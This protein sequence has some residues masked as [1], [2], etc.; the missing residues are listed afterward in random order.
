MA[1]DDPWGSPWA[2]EIQ[3]PHPI[4]LKEDDFAVKPTT[5]VKAASLAL[6]QKT[7]SPWDDADD[8]GFGDWNTGS[9]EEERGLGRDGAN[10]GWESNT[11]DGLG[12][13]LMGEGSHALSVSW[14]NGAITPGDGTPKLG[15]SLF[16][17]H[18]DILRQPSPD[19]WAVDADREH[20]RAVADPVAA[21]QPH[22]RSVDGEPMSDPSVEKEIATDVAPAVVTDR[23]LP[24]TIETGNGSPTEREAHAIVD[25]SSKSNVEGVETLKPVEIADQNG[26]IPETEHVSSRPSSSPSEHS[27]PEE[28]TQDSPRTSLDEE[29]KRPQVAR[30]V[31]TKVQELVEHFDGLAKQEEVVAPIVAR[32]GSPARK[33]EDVGEVEEGE[34]QDEMDD[35]G[36]FEDVQS[37]AE[38]PMDEGKAD[39]STKSPIAEDSIDNTHEPVATHEEPQARVV[40]K[41]LGP[42]QFTIDTTALDRLHPSTESE[43]PSEKLFIPDVIPH[44]SFSSTQERKTWYRISRYGPMRKYNTGDDENYVRV[45]WTQSQFRAETL[46]IV[47]RWI[48][49]D[50]ISGRVVLGG[51]S[52]GS[53]IFGWNDSKAAPIPLAAAFAVKNGKQKA[54]PAATEPAVDIPREWPKGLVRTRSTSNTPPQSKSRRKSSTKPVSSEDNIPG[55]QL[56]VA[57]FGWNATPQGVQ[58]SKPQSP[59]HG[60]KLSG[61]S[62]STPPPA[63]KIDPTSQPTSM[64]IS[65]PLAGPTKRTIPKNGIAPRPHSI[66][67]TAI[68]IPPSLS[69]ANIANDDDE[70]GELVSS[71]ST[72]I[73][74]VLPPPS[75]SLH[76]TTGSLGSA[77][78]PTA[79][80]PQL[81]SAYLQLAKPEQNVDWASGSNQRLASMNTNS[82]TAN[83][84]NIF[85]QNGFTKSNSG[86]MGN[87]FSPTTQIAHKP[88]TAAS[89]DPWASADF[90][91]FETSTA[92]VSK[93]I[94]LLAPKSMP[95]KSVTFSTPAVTSTP[96]RNQ[97]SREELEQDRIVQSVVKGLPDLSYMLRK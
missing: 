41:D 80:M 65:S 78:P 25:E 46:K 23:V 97:K 52:K 7:N 19:P 35:F 73:P 66:A 39:S 61:S 8:D 81:V 91:F 96:P 29:P 44:D 1:M 2:D 53:S 31:S 69:T 18:S 3:T 38:E 49:E 57:D 86:Y 95:P 70:W 16:P 24:D 47:A 5:P 84:T 21:D 42:V 10:D 75:K 32:T 82:L 83:T 64:R 12:P 33:A 87:A 74:P 54:T 30:K 67:H 55:S 93:P 68:S 89:V 11:G 60:K 34:E 50:R 88:I 90:S 59:V 62:S 43:V 71:P 48:E 77:F 13:G 9:A 58:V 15:P 40:R 45:N 17:K 4:K 20:K 94:S 26:D 27:H 51:A 28:M 63:A 85:S 56:P 22:D 76:K 79:S 92:P 6:E 37:E 72:N 14:N 36:D